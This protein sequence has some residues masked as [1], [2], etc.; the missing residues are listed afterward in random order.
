MDENLRALKPTFNLARISCHHRLSRRT[1][2]PLANA[3][4]AGIG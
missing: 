4:P 2:A 1:V 3:V